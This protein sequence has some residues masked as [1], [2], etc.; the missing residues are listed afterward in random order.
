M[1]PTATA[2][3]QQPRVV[4]MFVVPPVDDSGPAGLKPLDTTDD[5]TIRRD[6]GSPTVKLPG[7]EYNV[8]KIK[9][10]ATLLFPFVTPGLSLGRF[11]IAPHPEVRDGFRDPVERAG[12][13]A[14]EHRGSPPPL[15]R[16]DARSPR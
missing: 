2:P 8:A 3:A 9:T 16:D 7:F 11:G 10:R 5:D 6:D 13:A 4:D 1:P 12:A 15:A 14:D